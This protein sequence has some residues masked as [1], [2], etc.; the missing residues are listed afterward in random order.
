ML[1]KCFAIDWINIVNYSLVYCYYFTA[2]VK[3][4]ISVLIITTVILNISK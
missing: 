1:L 2:T 4:N 3:C